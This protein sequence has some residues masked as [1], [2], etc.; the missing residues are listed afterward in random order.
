MQIRTRTQNGEEEIESD[1][2]SVNTDGAIENLES[3]EE[4]PVLA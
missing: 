4:T 2:K 1:E 3:D